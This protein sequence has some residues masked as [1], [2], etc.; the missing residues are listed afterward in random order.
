MS[1]IST[2]VLD[3]AR[4]RPAE[5]VPITLERQDGNGTFARLGQ[6]ATDADGRL[7]TLLG[8]TALTAGI[9]RLTFDTA[10]YFRTTGSEGF[11]PSVTVLFEVK[12]PAQHHHVPL[13][14]S[15]YGYSTY[16]GS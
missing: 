8:N 10:T 9:Y 5:G 6:G 15:P 1:S 11:Y 4:G 16:R 3:V 14:L 2:H 7:R 12:N 13:L